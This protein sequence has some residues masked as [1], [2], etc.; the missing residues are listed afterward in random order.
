M[1]KMKTPKGTLLLPLRF[2]RHSIIVWFFFT[3]S[4]VSGGDCLMVGSKDWKNC[5]D[6]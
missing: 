2:Q 4:Q 1:N 5:R 6:W 3:M